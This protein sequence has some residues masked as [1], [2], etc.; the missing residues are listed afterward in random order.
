M[1]HVYTPQTRCRAGVARG[2]ITPPVGIYHRMWGAALH[3][4]AT[5]VHRPLLATLLLLDPVDG[6]RDQGQLIVALDHCIIDGVEMQ[7]IREAAGR[8]ASLPPERVQVAL[9]HTHGSAW[10]SRSRSHLPG[11]ELIG[12]YLDDLAARIGALAREAVAAEQPATLVYGQGRCSLAAHRDSWD[13]GRRQFVCGFNPSG[14]ADDTLLVARVSDPAG[15]TLATVVNYACH[16]TTLAWENTALSPDWVGAMRE[17]V[18]THTGAPCVFLQGASGDLGPREGF[19]GDW[20]VADRNGRQ[21]GFAALSALEALP[22]GGTRFS[23]S[24]PV[25]SGTVIGTWKHEPLD[26]AALHRQAAWQCDRWTVDLPYR[27]DLPTP[28]EAQQALT[29]YAAEEDK[30]RAE[31]HTV[32]MREMRAMAEQMRRQLARLN[33]LPAGKTYPYPVTLCRLGESRWLF[34]PGE[35]YQTFQVTLRHRFADVPFV[36]STVTGDWQPGYLPAASSY[37]YGIYQDVIA[38]VGPGALEG[39]IEAIARR[40]GGHE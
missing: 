15:R 29:R 22:R 32:R 39:L 19:V 11:G 18:E 28:E 26:D 2:D 21:V 23:Y 17:V 12:P 3:D 20:E 25:L 35:L 34:L 6:P 16:P 36:I 27:H 5:G 30:A 31:G 40:I 10:L 1:T 4:R 13:A 8:A 9:S 38:A 14:P 33:A 24:G 37:G 7:G